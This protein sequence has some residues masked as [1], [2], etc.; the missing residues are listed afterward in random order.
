[1]NDNSSLSMLLFISFFCPGGGCGGGGVGGIGLL[2]AKDLD[3]V[4][5]MIIQ[6][7]SDL[8]KREVTSQGKVSSKNG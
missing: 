6:F 8:R 2:N 1:M 3:E 4:V 5:L 7:V